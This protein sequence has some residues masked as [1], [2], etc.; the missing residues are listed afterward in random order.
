MI[1]KEAKETGVDIDEVRS[2]AKGEVDIKVTASA[3][4]QYE[5]AK[6]RAPIV[7]RSLREWKGYSEKEMINLLFTPKPEDFPTAKNEE[8]ICLICRNK[9]A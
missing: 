8:G 5:R 2:R 1:R 4:Q 7:L 6:V 3:S 9:C